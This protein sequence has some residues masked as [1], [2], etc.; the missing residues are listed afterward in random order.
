MTDVRISCFSLLK[1]VHQKATDQTPL[2]QLHFL[3]QSTLFVNLWAQSSKGACYCRKSVCSTVFF[4]SIFVEKSKQSVCLL[5][6]T[7]IELYTSFSMSTDTQLR[8]MCM[9]L[10]HS[11]SCFHGVFLQK[12]N[13][14]ISIWKAS[15]SLPPVW[16]NALI[17]LNWK[18]DAE[19]S[20]KYP[21]N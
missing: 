4:R 12:G 2:R 15:A 20:P 16:V 13:W 1:K 8:A 6:T 9:Y 14:L 19:F 3:L 10:L 18:N 21:S 7:G 11:L 17:C 5:D